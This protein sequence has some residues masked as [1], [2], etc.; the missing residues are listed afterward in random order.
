MLNYLL[1]GGSISRPTKQLIAITP[2]NSVIVSVI[3]MAIVLLYDMI[4][5]LLINFAIIIS[6]TTQMKRLK[7]KAVRHL[8]T[9]YIFSYA[10]DLWKL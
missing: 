1:I 8:K 3:V 9:N 6:L 2:R 7:N 4:N 10:Q 5:M